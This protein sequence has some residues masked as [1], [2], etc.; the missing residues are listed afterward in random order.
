MKSIVWKIGILSVTL[1]ICA[2]FFCFYSSPAEGSPT[3]IPAE[4]VSIREGTARMVSGET[5]SKAGSSPPGPFGDHWVHLQNNAE[6]D[7]YDSRVAPYSESHDCEANAGSN[8]D[9]NDSEAGIS[10]DNNAK[11]CGDVSVTTAADETD[12]TLQNN[13]EVT[14]SLNYSS[15]EWVLESIDSPEWYT[16]AGGGPG[17]QI[18]GEYGSKPGAYEITNNGFRAYNNAEMTFHAGQYHFDTFELSNNVNFQVDPE[19]GE[20]E[21]VE[22]YVE[23]SIIFENNS[24]LLPP[25]QIT[26]DT[27]KLRFYFEGTTTVDL[28]N[29][30]T[31]YGF[32]YAPNA[33]IEIENNMSIYGNVVGKEVYIWNNAAVH[34]DKAL[35]DE[36][37]GNIFT[38]GIPALP[39]ERVDWKEIIN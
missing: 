7:S 17:G 8:C 12:I 2:V 21:V 11:V 28:S 38:G 19:I 3:P 10:L 29:N 1:S 35:V 31:F 9:P 20:D 6:V 23:N 4:R 26:G 33:R 13:S 30:V 14:G 25:I 18:V 39:H 34:Y 37:F 24:E 15:A 22:I 36:D 5:G 32:M 16:A 27:T